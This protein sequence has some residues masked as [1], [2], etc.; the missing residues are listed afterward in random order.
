MFSL[1]TIPV[2]YTWRIIQL[3][4]WCW[5]WINLLFLVVRLSEIWWRC[6]HGKLRRGHKKIP[7]LLMIHPILH[8][9]TIGGW[10]AIYVCIV[11]HV[12]WP[13]IIYKMQKCDYVNGV[14]SECFVVTMIW[15]RPIRLLT[16]WTYGIKNSPTGSTRAQ[17]WPRPTIRPR[18]YNA[19]SK[20]NIYVYIHLSPQLLRDLNHLDV[21]PK[22]KKL[23]I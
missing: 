20:S 10:R 1:I 16:P 5:L 13:L 4:K 6:P 14:S 19:P 17:P 9:N 22:R 11:K 3:N 8:E 2:T 15:Y 12:Y 7:R 18:P 21:I 23:S